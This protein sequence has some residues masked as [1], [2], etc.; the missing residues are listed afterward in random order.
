MPSTERSG[1]TRGGLV[2]S[3]SHLHIRAVQE[4]LKYW[5]ITLDTVCIHG[6]QRTNS[7]RKS[8]CPVGRGSYWG[9]T[10]VAF[11]H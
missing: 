11:P 4:R 7:G 3:A 1:I 5:H 9:P 8:Y 2:K 10:P 6:M